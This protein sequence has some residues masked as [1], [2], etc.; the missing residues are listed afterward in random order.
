MLRAT[1]NAQSDME[2]V[3]E[4]SDGAEAV[5]AARK[6]QPE[7]ALLDVKMSGDDGITAAREIRR[8]SPGSRILMLTALEDEATLLSAL[9]AGAHGFLLKSASIEEILDG[10]RVMV[11]SGSVLSPRSAEQLVEQFRR[12]EES[13][14]DPPT[15]SDDD[16]KRLARLTQRERDVLGLLSAGLN[17]RE[18]GDKLCISELTAKTHVQNLLRRLEA[19]DRF[20]AAALGIRANLCPP[21]VSQTE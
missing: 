13:S 3:A 19:R 15:V 12:G 9:K 5:Q 16:Q 2:V 18:I 11:K 21:E 20:Q 4:A 1:L 6:H 10:V 8:Y 14:G 17:N 7:V